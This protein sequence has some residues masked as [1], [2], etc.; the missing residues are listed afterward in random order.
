MRDTTSRASD[1]A[2]LTPMATL[3]LFANLRESAGTDTVDIEAATVGELISAASER[4]GT[5]FSEGVTSAGV[6]VNGDTAM[7][8][9]RLADGDEVALIPPVSGGAT[10]VRTLDLA[11]NIL[12]V[13]LVISLLAVAW[14]APEWFVIVA[15][16]AILAWVWDVSD[17]AAA[18]RDAFVVFPPLIASSAG[19]AFAYAW[20]F[21]GFAGALAL[22]VVVAVS[23]PVFDRRH[24]DFRTTAATTF[25][26][27][28]AASASA[29]LVLVRLT[30]SYAVLAFVLITVFTL[31]GAWLAGTY[32]ASIQSV[33]A[34]V[35]ALLGAL[36]AGLLAGLVIS[37]LDVA[38]GLIGAVATAAGV[39][40]GRALGSMLRTGTVT[41]TEDAP[42]SLSMFDGAVIA[43]PLFWLAVWLF[44]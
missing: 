24:R 26:S 28:I 23:W 7:S 27:I 16:G 5:A 20:G 2:T 8:S 18:T 3:R 31:V 12:S 11:P 30:G 33:D 32:G 42:G 43:A 25:V 34:N 21:E 4:F 41:H 29:S 19:G 39:I 37:E 6:W 38:A 10:V 14:A 22:G 36:A 13:A 15:V 9:T 17:S 35:G 1:P 44:Q 40:A